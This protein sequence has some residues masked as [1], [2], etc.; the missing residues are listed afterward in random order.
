MIIQ[1]NS[2]H[3]ISENERMDAYFKTVIADSLNHY[4]EHITRI[5]VHF[6]DENGNKEGLNDKRCMLEARPEGKQ[7]VA[8]TSHAN[9]IEDALNSAIEKMIASLKTSIGQMKNHH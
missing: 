5:E 1:I 6:S 7:P 2:D 4:S 8:V 9:T 3:A